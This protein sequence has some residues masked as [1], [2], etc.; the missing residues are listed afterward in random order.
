[1]ASK[2]SKT[3]LYTLYGDTVNVVFLYESESGRY[4]GEYPDFETN[5]R[6]TD[7]GRRWVN[8]IK[9]DCQHTDSQYGD[10]GSCKH[11]ICEKPGDLIGVCDNE[12]LR[13]EDKK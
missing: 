9:D 12:K 5:P 10:C 3:R 2:K 6:F 7:C 8:S 4:F 1:M 11:Y 13:R